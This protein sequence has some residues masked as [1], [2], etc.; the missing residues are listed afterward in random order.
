MYA[1]PSKTQLYRHPYSK[2]VFAGNYVSVIISSKTFY[3]SKL[4]LLPLALT[5]EHPS[6]T[7][8]SMP[9]ILL[10]MLPLSMPVLLY[11]A[12]VTSLNKGILTS[13][14]ALQNLSSPRI[15]FYMI[16]LIIS[17][18][19]TGIQHNI[20]QPNSSGRTK[21]TMRK[22]RAAHAVYPCKRGC[23]SR[24]SSEESVADHENLEICG[25]RK[26][27]VL[28]QKNNWMLLKRV[29]LFAPQA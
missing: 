24:F 4:L 1:Y 11:A 25:S 18:A 7:Q 19:D 13:F 17:F 5:K 8:L 27:N 23:M 6:Q 21:T 9:I 3:E 2:P 20:G 26:K 10:Q 28:K 14:N 29:C 12:S 15:N 22:P 16:L